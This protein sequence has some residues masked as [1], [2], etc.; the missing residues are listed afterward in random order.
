[1]ARRLVRCAVVGLTTCAL[2]VS[3][4]GSTVAFAD[5]ASPTVSG[6][7]TGGGGIPIVFNGQPADAMNG[8]SVFD[9]ASV[10]YSQSEFFIE[11]TA[12][13]YSP[14]SALTTDGRWTVEA[15][16]Q[17]AYKT[18]MVVNR[19]IEPRHFNGTVVVEWLNVSGGV[20]GSP[21]WMHTHVELIRQGY[22]WVGVSAQAV[23]VAQLKCPNPPLPPP[24]CPIAPGG[25]APGDP[26]RYGSLNHPGDSYSYDMFSQAGQAIRDNAGLVL[27]GLHPQRLIAAGESQSAGRLAT[28]INAVHPLVDVYDGFLVHSR[29]AGS[30]ALSQAPLPAVP[31]PVP[32]LIRDDLAEPV[33][34]FQTETDVAGAIGAAGLAARQADSARYRLWE[35]AGTA[36]F[37]LYGLQ[38][39]QTD[40]GR[41]QSVAAW[42]DSMQN[43]T[44]EPRP[45]FVCGSPINT[46]PATFVL[47]SAISD[48]NRWVAHGT[49]PPRAPRLEIASVAPFQFALDAN[50]N[51]RG[52]IRTP[53]VDAPVARLSG[54]GQTGTPFCAAFGTT[55][56]FSQDQVEALYRSHG[57]FVV[58]W[59]RATLHAVTAGFILPRDA[60]L[61]GTV[62][63]EADVP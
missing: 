60:L 24:A 26:A 47:R 1:M 23:G 13:A 12:N 7:V 16:S 28:Y 36:H 39:G 61:I 3:A 59:N 51:V 27:G 14:T 30:A 17:A 43:P 46:G 22:A 15:S 20:D 34:A 58:A 54:L 42:F 55:E 38:T 53:A 52:G 63:A 25:P 41:R 44:N 19:P 4:G 6:P 9:L 5:A 29:G 48:L 21:D 10:G 35:V 49:P 8:V 40:T 57:R 62:G 33:L 31:T 45:G 2:V 37:D 11:G 56:P 50:G 32:T 18:R